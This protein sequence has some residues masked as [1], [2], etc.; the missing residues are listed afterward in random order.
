MTKMNIDYRCA[1]FV[2][3]LV[4]NFLL[5]YCTDDMAN[6]FENFENFI[7]ENELYLGLIM[8][9]KMYQII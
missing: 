9:V 8:F 5:F 2:Q 4:R 6:K 7:V 3:I 1:Q